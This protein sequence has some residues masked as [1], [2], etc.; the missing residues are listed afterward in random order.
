ME[1]ERCK[2]RGRREE[3]EEEG[4]GDVEGRGGERRDG[5]YNT[6]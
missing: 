3:G 4:G 1:G 2:F 5:K 6:W